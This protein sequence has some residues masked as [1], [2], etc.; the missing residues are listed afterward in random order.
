MK[1]V[2]LRYGRGR[3][4]VSVP[5]SADVLTC[6]HGAA[7][8]DPE[9]AVREALGG[10]IGTAPLAELLQLKRPR[11]V[12]I[13]VSDITRPVPNQAFLPAVLKT[14]NAAGI[15]DRDIVII[16]GT[17]MHRPSTAEERRTILGDAILSRVAVID[18]DATDAASLV[19]VSDGSDIAPGHPPVSVCRRFVE[20]E[21]RIVTGL[22]EHHFMAG[23]S[24]GRKGVCP[25]LVD[26]RTIQRFHGYKTL[27]HPRV[28]NGILEGNP[29]HAIASAVA[30][31]VG[32]DFLINVAISGDR[33]MAGI[34]C[35]DVEEAH[36]AGCRD[37]A[38]LTSVEVSGHHDLVVTCGGGYP[39]DETFYQTV[40]GMCSA[41]PALAE[42][43]TM[44]V[45]SSC[46][47]GIG[48]K[49]YKDIMARYGNDWQRFLR[50]I[51]GSERTE[52][53][54]WQFQMQA[55]VLERTGIERLVLVTDG[56]SAQEQGYLCVRPAAGDGDPRGRLQR[57]IDAYLRA[58]PKARV[59]VIPDGPYTA[60]RKGAGSEV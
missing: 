29:C 10:P 56:L 5:E 48:S 30:R 7:M 32:V 53:D 8:A 26:L 17:G 57:E 49:S 59:A 51:A 1:Q 12:A 36:L 35:G 16:I 9:A 55:Q 20:A 23:F 18:H 34:Y 14:I 13:T 2:G 39:L 6:P 43:G 46:R 24:G 19:Q 11:S 37:V 42:G 41:L 54:Q 45:A 21:F 50:D 44:I 38:R 33:R 52:L 60:L 3:L 40:K 47:E 25:A 4:E 28:G 31:R 22:I 15:A 58:H 27:S